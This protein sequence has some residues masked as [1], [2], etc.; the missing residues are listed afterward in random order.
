[1]KNKLNLDEDTIQKL[2][3]LLADLKS[4]SGDPLPEIAAVLHDA[5]IT[6]D[7]AITAREKNEP[8][9]F[10]C[11]FKDYHQKPTIEWDPVCRSLD[12][13]LLAS[14]L[15]HEARKVTHWDEHYNS[16]YYPF[17]IAGIER[18]INNH[19]STYIKFPSKIVF[20]TS[21]FTSFEL[22]PILDELDFNMAGIPYCPPRTSVDRE[23]LEK[24]KKFCYEQIYRAI[25]EDYSIILLN[26]TPLTLEVLQEL[27]DKKDTPNA[28]DWL[29]LS[30]FHDLD[31]L[32]NNK[33][34]VTDTEFLDPMLILRENQKEYDSF[35]NYPFVQKVSIPHGFQ[36]T[37]EYL[38]ALFAGIPQ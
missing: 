8:E 31:V 11:I 17:F 20:F 13:E 34:P 16:S 38:Q 36:I 30:F 23:F 18:L 35:E 10:F 22:S 32:A 28:S 2:Q 29:I 21:L 37:T 26:N 6:W 9:D 27:H 24:I 15:A 5:G 12:I 3:S 33:V 7:K 25:D 1:M 19:K 4:D 14:V